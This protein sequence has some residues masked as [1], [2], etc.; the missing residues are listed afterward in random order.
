MHED[1]AL[2]LKCRKRKE[3]WGADGLTPPALLSVTGPGKQDDSEDSLTQRSLCAAF[4][5]WAR[6][7]IIQKSLFE[8]PLLEFPCGSVVTTQLAAMRTQV[9]SLASLS[10]LRIWHCRQLWCR[11]QM[12]L[13]SCVAVVVA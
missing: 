2:W 7:P 10:G 8:M 13:G 3:G 11:S 12:W 4:A 9:R 1:K 5:E 6:Q